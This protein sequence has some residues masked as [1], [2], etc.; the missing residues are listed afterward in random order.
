VSLT[1]IG[2]FQQLYVEEIDF[3]TMTIMVSTDNNLDVNCFYIVTATRKDVEK[4]EVEINEY[5]TRN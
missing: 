4:L 1:P 2:K 5:E 3:D